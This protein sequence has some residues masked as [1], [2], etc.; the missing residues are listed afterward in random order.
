MG[1]KKRR[2]MTQDLLSRFRSKAD[3]IAYMGNQLQLYVPPEKMLNR[4]FMK[5]LLVEDKKLLELRAVRHANVPRYDELAVK[6][7]WPLMQKDAA[8]MQY[9]PDVTTEGR[10]PEREY[11]WNVLNTLQT[12]Y[13]QRLIEHANSQRMTVQEDADGADAIE[14]SE[15]WWRKLN[16]LPFVSQNRGRTLHLL[17]KQAKAVPQN[18]KRVKRDIFASPLDF[19]RRHPDFEEQKDEEPE[20]QVNLRSNLGYVPADGGPN[21]IGNQEDGMVVADNVKA[22]VQQSAFDDSHLS[23][24]GVQQDYGQALQ[25]PGTPQATHSGGDTIMYTPIMPKRTEAQVMRMQSRRTKSKE[26]PPQQ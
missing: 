9:M 19:Q 24:A 26:R 2:V 21:Q 8:F 11:F 4:D 16:A 14:I 7:F 20:M 5:Q 10:M 18:R 15:E 12:V 25:Q 1:T 3:F 6:K 23:R 17:K 22:K 13:V